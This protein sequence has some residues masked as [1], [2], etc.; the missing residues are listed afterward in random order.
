MESEKEKI[1]SNIKEEVTGEAVP[2]KK[3]KKLKE[4]KEKDNFNN[5]WYEFIPNE[6]F[7]EIDIRKVKLI[8]EVHLNSKI[9]IINIRKMS[10][11]KELS[12]IAVRRLEN[13]EYGLVTGVRSFLI[14][15]IFDRN[16]KAYVTELSREEFKEKYSLE[17]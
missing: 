8:E 13:G 6:E 14:G 9:S 11:Y 5:K 12:P 15:K 16:L 2:K 7:K 1:Q 4:D 3:K 10:M 17:I